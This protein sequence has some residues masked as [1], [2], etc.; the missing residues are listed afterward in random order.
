MKYDTL[1]PS[2][3]WLSIA[4]ASALVTVFVVGV[5]IRRFGNSQIRNVTLIPLC[6]M[7]VF[8]LGFHGH[9]LDLNYSAR[10]LARAIAAQAPDEKIVA[11]IGVRRD[12]EYGLAFYRNQPMQHYDNEHEGVP[13][14]EHVLV[15]PIND[16]ADLEH[17]LTGR[18][19]EPLFLYDMQGLEVYRVLAKPAPV[20]EI[21]IPAGKKLTDLVKIQPM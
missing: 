2:V 5:A 3:Q 20:E 4:A 9:D 13:D 14:A 8:L 11:L 7:L 12:L 18:I 10:P 6:A 15:A 17:Y 1:V 16:T 19:Y 21:P